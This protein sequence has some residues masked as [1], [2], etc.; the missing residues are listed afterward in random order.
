MLYG[1][2]YEIV[3]DLF[4]LKKSKNLPQLRIIGL[5]AL[6]YREVWDGSVVDGVDGLDN[7]LRLRIWAIVYPQDVLGKHTPLLTQV[8][9]GYP[10]NVGKD[11][12]ENM[13]IFKPYW[14]N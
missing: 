4:H 11:I 12:S 9:S 13:S 6:V 5:G 10:G 3:K 7:V 2:A 14:L 1:L 8:A